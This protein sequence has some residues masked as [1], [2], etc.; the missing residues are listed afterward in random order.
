MTV[1]SFFSGLWR[2]LDALRKALH[3][4]LL[5]VIFAIVVAALRGAVPRIPSK[6]ALLVAPQGELVEQLSSPTRCA[7]SA[8]AA[9]K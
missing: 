9:R 6:A 7:S 4:I 5:L 8:P 3:L 1:R 2:G